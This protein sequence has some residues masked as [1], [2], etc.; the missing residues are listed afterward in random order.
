LYTWPRNAVKPGIREATGSNG[1]S[2]DNFEDH[3]KE[4]QWSVST[5]LKQKF[6]IVAFVNK[7]LL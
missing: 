1:L 7:N 3:N 4:E 2:W 5:G 6:S